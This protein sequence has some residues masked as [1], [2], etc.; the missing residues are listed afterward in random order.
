MWTAQVPKCA[1][2]RP[3][4][5]ACASLHLSAWF[6][7]FAP[8]HAP[9]DGLPPPL[10]T[11]TSFLDHPY[12]PS[13]RF[14]SLALARQAV[15]SAMTFPLCWSSPSQLCRRVHIRPPN[16]PPPRVIQ[17]SN[18]PACPTSSS[19]LIVP[20]PATRAR[21]CCSRPHLLHEP[22]LLPRAILLPSA[23]SAPACGPPASAR[24]AVF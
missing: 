10:C 11:T 15:F 18:G 1:M 19:S 4:D 5:L 16:Y 2:Q 23:R 22:S 20:T 24:P 13:A 3:C 6:S 9:P 21:T 12:A 17:P 7:P 14:L 8:A